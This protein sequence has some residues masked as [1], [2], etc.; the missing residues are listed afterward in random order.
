MIMILKWLWFWSDYDSEVIMI[1]K[2]LWFWSGYNS[3]VVMILKWLWFWNDYKL[4]TSCCRSSPTTSRASCTGGSPRRRRGTSRG[5]P[6]GRWV[7]RLD[8]VDVEMQPEHPGKAKRRFWAKFRLFSNHFPP[9]FRLKWHP[10]LAINSS[11][12][13]ICRF[14]AHT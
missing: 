8:A 12:V 14:S 11:I 10:I 5:W 4:G 13:P 9:I 6:G 7:C 3:E 2:W 1:L